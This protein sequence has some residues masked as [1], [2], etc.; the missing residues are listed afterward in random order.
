MVFVKL[1]K[2]DLLKVENLNLLKIDKNDFMKIDKIIN[3]HERSNG[4]INIARK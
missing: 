1:D 4:G 2:N 3:R